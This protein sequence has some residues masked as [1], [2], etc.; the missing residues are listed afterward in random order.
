[1]TP[2][3]FLKVWLGIGVALVALVAFLSLSPNPLDAGRFHEV[4]L[5]HVIA[6]ATL[7]LWFAQIFRSTQGRIAVG[8][9]LALLGVVLEYLQGATGYRTFAY[10]DMRDNTLGVIA[11]L[12]LAY[13]GLG[14]MLGR[15]DGWL[16]HR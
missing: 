4:K 6:Y 10:S 15:L 7:M 2:L 13:V 3:R 9:S 1:M 16:A 5:G 11:G 8:L 12:T 14:G